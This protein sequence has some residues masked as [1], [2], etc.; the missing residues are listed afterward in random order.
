MDYQSKKNQWFQLLALS[1]AHIAIDFFAGGLHVIMPAFQESFGFSIAIGIALLSIFNLTCNFIQVSIGHTRSHQSKPFF[2]P[3]G[4]IFVAAISLVV[5]LPK[6][7]NSWLYM[8][9][10]IVISA[11]GVAVTH[12]ESLRAIHRFDKI[13]PSVVS[14]IYMNCGFIGFALGGYISSLLISIFG[15]KGLL[16]LLV[17][18]VIGLISVFAAKIKLPVE[19][20]MESLS[21]A[22]NITSYPFPLVMMMA[23]P[24]TIATVILSAFLPQ[25][26]AKLDLELTYGGI[27][28]MTFIAG[29]ALGTFFW[30]SIAHKIGELKVIIISLILGVPFIYIYLLNIE[31]KLALIWLLAGGF[32]SGAAFSLIVTLGRFAKGLNLGSR[33]GF[34]V[35]GSWGI[36]SAFLLI[37]GPAAKRFGTAPIL[38][39]A[40][41]FYLFSAV[42]GINLFQIHKRITK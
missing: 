37:L 12:P 9:P 28:I 26:I 19:T 24:F 41:M 40:P 36:A 21:S 33:M 23:V 31:N 15:L 27:V 14:A 20:E 29:S 17:L 4:L 13:R 3:I 16:L 5:F 18:P 32:C 35:G 42:I 30:A 2:L 8:I 22:H 1:L 10:L 39:T 38:Y 25:H 34:V 11:A 6:Q 7:S